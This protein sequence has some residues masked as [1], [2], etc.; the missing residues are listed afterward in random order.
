[1]KHSKQSKAAEKDQVMQTMS[2]YCYRLCTIY[3]IE[4]K[5]L[6]A[7]ILGKRNMKSS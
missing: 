6:Q 1:M 3:F 4:S 2:G 7:N 5:W